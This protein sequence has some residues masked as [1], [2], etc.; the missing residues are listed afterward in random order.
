MCPRLPP[1]SP[2][3]SPCRVGCIASRATGMGPTGTQRM[4][5]RVAPR[6]T[7]ARPTPPSRARREKCSRTTPSHEILGE[8]VHV[9]DLEAPYCSFG[10]GIV[11][12]RRLVVILRGEGCHAY[13]VCRLVGQSVHDDVVNFVSWLLKHGGINRTLLLLLTLLVLPFFAA[14]E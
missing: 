6:Q 3:R 9:P 11:V 7:G 1:R 2:P 10:R 5:T 8:I 12:S 4:H 14:L 13:L